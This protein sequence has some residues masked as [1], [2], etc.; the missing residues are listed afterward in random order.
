MIRWR[1]TGGTV[2]V[3]SGKPRNDNVDSVSTLSECVED[4]PEMFDMLVTFTCFN[5]LHCFGVE[6]NWGG[7]KSDIVSRFI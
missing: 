3:H 2:V 6:N 5:L 1:S 7:S 4:T